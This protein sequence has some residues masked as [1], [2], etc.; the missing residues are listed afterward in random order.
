MPE[1]AATQGRLGSFVLNYRDYDAHFSRG[2]PMTRPVAF[3][4]LPMLLAP[5]T[6]TAKESAPVVLEKT[7]NWEVNYD[8]D[9]CHLASA[10][11]EGDQRI[12]ARFTKFQPGDGFQL[13]LYGKPVRGV[14]ART[15][16]ALDFGLAKEPMKITGLLGSNGTLPLIIFNYVHFLP[17]DETRSVV[18]ATPRQEAAVSALTFQL[19]GAKRYRLVFKTMGPPMVAM[20]TC[21]AD[22]E[23]H[24]GYDPTVLAT[25]SRAPTPVGSPGNW[26]TDG[27]YPRIAAAKGHNGLVHFRLD[28]DEAGKV[29][30]CTV[31][32][33]TAPDDFENA[34]CSALIR[35]ARL[36]PA[37][38]ASGKPVKS[39]YINTVRWMMGG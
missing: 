25:L 4:L 12:I 23:R 36:E 9:S 37:L 35:R 6:V 26:V 38:D 28:I 24:W 16:V 29:L 31:I 22:L 18:V 33:K 13:I 8:A 34:T 14:D 32:A 7:S 17:L 2:A 20:R 21:L 10:F 3:L 27:D 30:K 11:G 5:T 39:Y 19:A 1:C 15:Q